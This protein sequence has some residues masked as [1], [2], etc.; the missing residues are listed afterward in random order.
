VKD[1]CTA[2]VG[3]HCLP[4][5]ESGRQ[6]DALIRVLEPASGEIVTDKLRPAAAVE[7][8]QN[9]RRKARHVYFGATSRVWM[10]HLPFKRT[11]MS[12]LR[13]TAATRGGCSCPLE[14]NTVIQ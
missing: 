9:E 1:T 6:R 3:A 11:S 10:S 4:R 8:P 2:A 14:A 7:V 5:L 13:P 12:T